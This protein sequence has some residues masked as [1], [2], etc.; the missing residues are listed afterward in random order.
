MKKSF[1]VFFVL[2][3]LSMVYPF[4]E[5][6]SQEKAPY[7]RNPF[8]TPEEEMK[9]RGIKPSKTKTRENIPLQKLNLSGIIYGEKKIAIINSEFYTEG[10]TISNFT[11]KEIK[12]L[13]VILKT[14]VREM[15][16]KLKHVLA[17]SKTAAKEEE[18][19]KET[20][21]KASQET[22]E[23]T[24]EAVKKLLGITE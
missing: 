18:E 23:W 9:E 21:L 5:A 7:L 19:T 2:I 8:L 3:I 22:K 13:S 17:A 6:F 12:L 11:I 10:D 20:E 4:K 14:D 15:E 24:D 16:L 1:L